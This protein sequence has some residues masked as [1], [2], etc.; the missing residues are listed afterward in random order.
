MAERIVDI[1]EVVEVDV[2]DGG[3]RGTAAHFL[4]DRLQAFPEI[5]AVGQAAKRVVHGKMAQT[6]LAG[7]NGRC[8]PAHVSQHE[9]GKQRE[10]DQRN[11]DERNDVMHNLGARP[12]RRP[13]ET[14]DGLAV[15][16][17]EIETEIAD[18]QRVLIE[19][20]Q[21]GQSQLCGNARE[22]PVVDEFYRHE[23]RR[24]AVDRCRYTVA[25]TNRDRRDHRRAVH[26]PPDHRCLPVRAAV[27]RIH[28]IETDR[29]LRRLV[30]AAH[31]VDYRAEAGT[32]GRKPFRVGGAVIDQRIDQSVIAIENEDVVVV[33]I[34]FQPRPDALIDPIVI[35]RTANVLDRA[36]RGGDTLRFAQ[37][38]LAVIAERA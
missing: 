36:I 24:N 31:E 22:R 20:A 35:E 21:I 30:A 7:R 33:E 29:A 19:L 3:R 12:F 18:G 37:Y 13:G 8:C 14:A 10:T 16:V 38:T 32:G 17:V 2:E 15:R 5:D 26:Q 27:G 34:G 28:L 6:R 1:L 25:R 9:S 23:N 4:D 11:R